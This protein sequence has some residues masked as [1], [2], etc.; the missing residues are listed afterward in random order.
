VSI[1]I[2]IDNNRNSRSIQSTENDEYEM[3]DLITEGTILAEYTDAGTEVLEKY[4]L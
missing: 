2:S 1:P 3:A 4:K